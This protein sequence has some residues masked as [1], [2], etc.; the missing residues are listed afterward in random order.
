MGKF[1]LVRTT[2]LVKDINNG[3]RGFILLDNEDSSY[4]FFVE[5]NL[6][7]FNYSIFYSSIANIKKF[8]SITEED[9]DTY[10][11]IEIE[12]K[13][14][15]FSLVDIKNRKD[16]FYYNKDLNVDKYKRNNDWVCIDVSVNIIDKSF[17]DYI[18]DLI[19]EKKRSIDYEKKQIKREFEL[20][21]EVEKEIENKE[22]SYLVPDEDINI[23]ISFDDPEFSQKIKLKSTEELKNLMDNAVKS[24]KYTEAAL[25]RDTIEGR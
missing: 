3:T 13:N 25:L 22:T 9:I 16:S 5:N 21:D 12:K 20:A 8:L 19:L 2:Y 17:D 14:N 24:Q 6:F 18:D 15:I 7:I 1:N 10:Q 11:I 4:S 23:G